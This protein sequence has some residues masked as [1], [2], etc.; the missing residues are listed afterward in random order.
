MTLQPLFPLAV[1]EPE[2]TGRSLQLSFYLPLSNASHKNHL[3][4]SYKKCLSALSLN[5]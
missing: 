4:K 1:L 2:A 3:M 5:F